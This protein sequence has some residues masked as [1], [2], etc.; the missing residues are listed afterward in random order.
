MLAYLD[1]NAATPPDERIVSYS[2]TL[3]RC[4]F[5]N[6]SNIF[7]LPGR[8]ARDLIDKSRGAIGHIIGW[9]DGSIVFTS[10]CTEANNLL[11]VSHVL[12][13]SRQGR[14]AHIVTS[15]IEHPSILAPLVRL[16]DAR[17]CRI[18]LVPPSANGVVDAG[19]MIEALDDTVTLVSLMS[20]NNETGA[21]QP[22]WEVSA[23]CQR[24]GIF[25]HSDISQALGKVPLHSIISSDLHAVTFSPHKFHGLRGAGVLAFRSDPIAREP[26]LVGGHQEA[27]L[28]AGTENTVAIACAAR[29][30]EILQSEEEEILRKRKVL[31]EVLLDVLQELGTHRLW[32][33]PTTTVPGCVSLSLNGV[34]ASLLL[35]K[36]PDIAFSTGSACAMIDRTPSHVLKALGATS[37]EIDGFIRLSVHRFNTEDEIRLGVQKIGRTANLVRKASMGIFA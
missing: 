20:V 2:D 15:S 30:L 6:P 31:G 1:A 27:G 11:L 4:I 29:A 33:G 14:T 37:G 3:N 17:L 32:S 25:C 18:T 13:L 36:L 12:D 28:R 9:D 5:G 16:S 19:R 24:H 22:V 7:S 8:E 26:L 21:I 10:G 23:W 35:E 34:E